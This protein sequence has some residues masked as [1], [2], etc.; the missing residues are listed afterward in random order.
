MVLTPASSR[1]WL[2]VDHEVFDVSRAAVGCS[3]ALPHPVAERRARGLLRQE[4]GTG[5]GRGLRSNC[6][7]TSRW[8][9]RPRAAPRPHASRL[10]APPSHRPLTD[11]GGQGRGLPLLLR[12][13]PLTLPMV[14][15]ESVLSLSCLC[16]MLRIGGLRTAHQFVEGES[17]GVSPRVVAYVRVSTDKQVEHGL[18]LEA[19]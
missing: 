8:L 16:S 11:P 14:T 5:G 10:N 13:P 3:G 15:L 12:A 9:R 4:R 18:S 1:Q 6:V 2:I 17:M 7:D 19:Q